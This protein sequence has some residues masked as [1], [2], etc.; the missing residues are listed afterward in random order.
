MAVILQC[1]SSEEERKDH[2]TSPGLTH[3][4]AQPLP[5]VHQKEWRCCTSTLSNLCLGPYKH[6]CWLREGRYFIQRPVVFR[7]I[8]PFL[9]APPPPEMQWSFI[10]AKHSQ[11]SY[12]L[13]T[14]K[15]TRKVRSLHIPYMRSWHSSPFSLSIH[16]LLPTSHAWRHRTWYVLG[17]ERP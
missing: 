17:S 2:C 15:S 13:L 16:G 7:V 12:Y 8:L 1:S 14:H 3:A 4:H 6:A 9:H 10:T 11:W 5:T